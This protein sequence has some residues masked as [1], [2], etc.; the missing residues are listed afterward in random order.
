MPGSLTTWGRLALAL[1]HK[2]LLPSA[3]RKASAPQ[4]N[5]FA[6]QWLACTPPVNA[7]RITSRSYTHDSGT[8]WFA[9]PS[10]EGL[11]PFISSRSPGA[12]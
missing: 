11:S 9:T 12:P 10:L 2:L 8:V 1:P 6:A 4:I 7:S 5:V 3:V